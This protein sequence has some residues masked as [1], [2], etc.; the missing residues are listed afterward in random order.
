LLGF[1]LRVFRLVFK[2]ER[3]CGVNIIDISWPLSEKTTGYKNKKTVVF[4]PLKIFERDGAR[5]SALWLTTHSGTHVDAPTHMLKDGKTID[6]LSLEMFCGPCVVLELM[7]VQEKITHAWLADQETQI[8]EGDIVIFKT[9]NSMQEPTDPF[10]PNFVYLD[11]SG[12]EYLASKKIKAVGVDYLGIERNQ[13]GHLTHHELL[14]HNIGIIEGLR[15]GH[16]EPGRYTFICLP[17]SVIGLDGAPARA[18]LIS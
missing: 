17:L 2:R 3:E 13:P 11:L 6:Q 1:V 4:E 8:K 12:A 7:L 5:E 18:V 10:M 15:L 16:V 9:T 14:T